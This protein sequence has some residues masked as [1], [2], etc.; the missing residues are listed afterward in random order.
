[1]DPISSNLRSVHTTNLPEILNQLGVSLLVSTYQAGKL[2]VVRADG[3]QLNTHFR[4]FQKPMGL[5]VEGSKLAIGC[6]HQIWEHRN[7]P[8]V[9]EKLD[10]P[11]KHDACFIPRSTHITGDIDIH[12]MAYGQEG[13]WFLNTRFSCLCSLDNEHSFVPRWRPP[14]VSAYD[15]TDRCHLNGLAMVGG[16]PCYVTALG[17]TDTAGGW[18]TN[19]ANGGL[20]MDI[21]ANQIVLRGLSMPHSPRWYRDQLWVLESGQ[22]TLAR[23]DPQRGTWQTVAEMPGFTRG[24]DFC[25]PIAFIGLSKVRESAVFSGIPITQKLTERICGVWVVN[26]ESGQTLGFLRFEE[27]VEEIFAVQVLPNTRFPEVLGDPRFND[28]QQERLLGTSYVLP[29]EALKQMASGEPIPLFRPDSGDQDP[30]PMVTHFAVVV[31]VFNVEQKG[32]EILERTL[33]SIQASIDFFYQKYPYSD[34]MRHEIVIVDDASTDQTWVLLQQW[35]SPRSWVKLVRQEQNQGQGAGRNRGVAATT[36]QAIFFCDD[37]DLF[38][39]NH[40]LT[41]LQLLNRPLNPN[42]ANPIYRLPGSYPAAVKTGLKIEDPL[43]PYWAEQIKQVHTLNLCIRREAHEFIEGFPTQA[44]FRQSIYGGE[45]QVYAAWLTTFFSIIWIPDQTVD[46]IRYPGNHLDFQ[47]KKFQSAPN[48]YQEPISTEQQ[49]YLQQIAQITQSHLQHLHHKFEADYNPDHLFAQAQSSS[50]P[51]QAIALLKRC[52]ALDPTMQVAQQALAQWDPSSHPK[53][54]PDSYL[55][56]GIQAHGRGERERAAE[57]FRRCLELDPTIKVARYN[58]GVTCGDI[59]QWQEAE[60]HLRLSIQEDPDNARTH[61]SLG[62]TFANQNRLDEAIQLYDKAIELDPSFADAHMNKGM[63]LLKLGSLWD[64]WKEFE[65]RWQT[66]QFTVFKCPHPRWTGE[67]ISQKTL[68]VHTEQGAGDAIQFVRFIPLALQRCQDLIVV[69]PNHLTRLFQQV[70]GIS[71][72]YNAGD[73]PLAAFQVYSP[74]MSLPGCLDIDL[75]GIPNQ[76]PYLKIP[77]VRPDLQSQL[78]LAFQLQNGRSHALSGFKAKAN[79]PTNPDPKSLN[80]GICWAGSS[81]QGNDHNRSSRLQDW[82]PLLSLKGIQF[83]SLQKGPQVSQLDQLPTAVSVINW[84]PYLQD[85]ADTAALLAH[86]D[87]LISVDTSVVHLAGA[88]GRPTWT[89]LCHNCDWRWLLEREDTPYYPTMRLFRQDTPKQ[90]DPVMHKAKDSLLSL[91]N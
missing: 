46:Y 5:A 65:W 7:I 80:V 83:H 62:Y 6:A 9:G 67:D 34:R 26:I 74:M 64:G 51:A 47:L 45:D 60:H 4:V 71:R 57:Y 44:P 21:A 22:G 39:P 38:L 8:A 88:L 29:D 52:L 15:L 53:E 77:P 12:E 49:G 35:A 23:V 54:D 40:V 41:C 68:L 75:K 56:Q 91:I 10:P 43:H 82:L 18:R 16:I 19:K 55:Q 31:P 42:T 69:C 24:I 3:A 30:E 20:L 85:Y 36:A 48:T 79:R 2:I 76:V 58:L 32:W 70:S 17:E 50:D 61:N 73:I 27:G 78:N 84:D 59:E 87:L 86:L 72:I 37:D 81:T 14:F 13:L 90:W 1:M 25:G 66:N 11:G 89:L 28:D 33:Q 63:A